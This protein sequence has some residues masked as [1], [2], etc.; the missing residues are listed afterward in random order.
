MQSSKKKK[1]IIINST[2]NKTKK[3]II[4]YDKLKK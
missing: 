4:N 2:I 3:T 1:K